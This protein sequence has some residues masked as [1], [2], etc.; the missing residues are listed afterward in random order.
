[1]IYDAVTA[2][3]VKQQP[4][5]P[6]NSA[7]LPWTFTIDL[8]IERSF[9]LGNYQLVPY[10][11]VKN[12]SITKNVIAVY[13]GTGEA[14]ST[15]YLETDDG[16]EKAQSTAPGNPHTGAVEGDMYSYRYDLL[17]NNPNNYSNHA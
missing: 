17:Q 7:H 15:G 11:W 4:A 9:K 16:Q 14:Y 5:S 10:L 1:V 3:S 8:K 12:C 13:E 6:I 2:A